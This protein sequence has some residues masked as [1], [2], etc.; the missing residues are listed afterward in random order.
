M[1]RTF[2]VIFRWLTLLGWRDVTTAPFDCAIELAVF[3]VDPRRLAFPCLR[4]GD[5]WVDATTM[6]PI[7]VSPTHWRYWQPEVLPMSCC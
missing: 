1:R 6:Q 2:N 7:E 5:A 3:D 4:H